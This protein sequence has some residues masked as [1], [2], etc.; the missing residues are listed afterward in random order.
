MTIASS[1]IESELGSEH[2]ARIEP[3][4]DFATVRR[5]DETRLVAT[6]A[7][8]QREPDRT[9]QRRK[10]HLV[11]EETHHRAAPLASIV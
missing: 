10:F 11:V 1:P 5:A 3:E 6:A 2:T 9:R 7:C 8:W 4:Q